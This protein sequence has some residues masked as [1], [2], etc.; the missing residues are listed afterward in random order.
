MMIRFDTR[1]KKP[2]LRALQALTAAAGITSVTSNPALTLTGLDKA[3]AA[4]RGLKDADNDPIGARPKFLIVPPALESTAL[5]LIQASEIVTGSTGDPTGLAVVPNIKRY[6]SRFE[7]VTSEYLGSASPFS[8]NWGDKKWMLL[9]D[10]DDVPLMIL[11]YYQN[12]KTPTIK[13]VYGDTELDGLRYVL[14]WGV[15]VSVAE[16]KSCVVSSPS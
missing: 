6:A 15:G 12:Q 13:T 9:A 1:D 7:V 10:P 11:S 8:S 16:K 5:S 4:F 14:Y 2:K 3:F